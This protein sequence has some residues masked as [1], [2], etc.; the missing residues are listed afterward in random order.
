M[1]SAQIK[2]R[3]KPQ[4]IVKRK[5]LEPKMATTVR[6]GIGK[7]DTAPR[8]SREHDA[9]RARSTVSERTRQGMLAVTRYL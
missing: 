2:T 6:G 8:D 3:A 1:L 7:P 5:Q 9:S 4:N